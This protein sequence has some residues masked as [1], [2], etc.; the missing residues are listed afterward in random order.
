ML[1]DTTGKI[2][3]KKVLRRDQ[4]THCVFADMNY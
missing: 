1:V 3:S 4:G 2:F